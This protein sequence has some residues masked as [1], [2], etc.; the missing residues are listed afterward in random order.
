MIE[1]ENMEELTTS[2]NYLP[3]PDED[4]Q[5]R[6]DPDYYRNVINDRIDDFIAR[7]GKDPAKIN[8]NDLMAA[9]IGIRES[10]FKQTHAERN[11]RSN[12][13][14]TTN[15]IA[16]LLDIYINIVVE[17]GAHPSLYGFSWL[18][19]I[20]EKTVKEY[21]TP[22]QFA[23]LNIRREMLR[24]SLADD[25]MGRIVLANNDSSYGLEY[26]KKQATDREQI[27]QLHT[28]N[29]LPQLIETQ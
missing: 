2:A 11:R 27:R 4:G 23:I 21:V 17:R 5:P 12:I 18:T 22:A 9:F 19:G 20:E 6:I 13:P 8:G 14:Y 29:E 3:E 10:I 26:E 7:K 25:R 1:G 16:A 15:N 24:N 28:A